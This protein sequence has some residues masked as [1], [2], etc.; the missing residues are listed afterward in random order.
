ML[1]NGADIVDVVPGERGPKSD[2]NIWRERKEIFNSEQKF[3]GDKAYI[4]ESQ[5]KTPH[6]KPKKQE[7][8]AEQKEENK[9]FSS[10][11]V[12]VEHVIRLVKIFRVAGERFRL[13]PNKY[14]SVISTI[15]GLVRLRIGALI[16]EVVEAGDRTDKNEINLYHLWSTIFTENLSNPDAT[17]HLTHM[18]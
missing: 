5:I 10:L 17:V 11:R 15:C 7:L 3:A 4:G 2:I 1:P 16:L 13:K 6:K 9:E 8:T 18:R 14:N 12:F